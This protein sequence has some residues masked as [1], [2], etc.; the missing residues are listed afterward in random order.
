LDKGYDYQAVRDRRDAL[1]MTAPIR[2]R[3][4]EAKALTDLPGYRAPLGG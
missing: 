2:S 3:A 1:G 4:E